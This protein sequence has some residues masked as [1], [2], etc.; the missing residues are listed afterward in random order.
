MCRGSTLT[1]DGRLIANVRNKGGFTGGIDLGEELDRSQ[2][3]DS[4]P[5]SW[6]RGQE[7]LGLCQCMEYEEAEGLLR[8][9]GTDPNAAYDDGTTGLHMA[10]V[11]NAVEWAS[12]CM[13]PPPLSSIFR[14]LIGRP[15]IVL[16]YGADKHRKNDFGRT[17]L[18]FARQVNA[19]DI[20]ELL[21]QM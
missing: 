16:R 17:P 6:K 19:Q 10:A 1:A 11:N 14:M 3:E 18:D 8:D 9:E 15:T 5:D 2:Y 7:L 21:E 4:Q 13:P 20:I 12:L